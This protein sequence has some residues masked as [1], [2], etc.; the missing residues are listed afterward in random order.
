M[1]LRMGLEKG[2]LCL[3]CHKKMT[4]GD[5]LYKEHDP[6]A[7][8]DC[9]LCHASHASDNF[10]LLKE[11]SGNLCLDCHSQPATKYKHEPV[12]KLN[13]VACHH[14]HGSVQDKYLK[15]EQPKLCLGCH[16]PISQ[17]WQEGVAHQPAKEDCTYCHSA[18]GSD[19]AYILAVSSNTLCADCHELESPGFTTIHKG[20]K[21][22]ADS[23]LGCHDPH[24]GNDKSLL[25]PVIH[26]PFKK[27]SC[28][29]C[30]K[31]GAK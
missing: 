18:H 20:I 22:S 4:T 13:C 21:P 2:E 19:N 10:N 29:P 27:G 23:C 31:G 30:H 11:K 5:E 1:L 28:K 17:F 6:Y 24:G 3:S 26:E 12:D 7:K 25:Y 9:K 16:G 14:A 15:M 8:A